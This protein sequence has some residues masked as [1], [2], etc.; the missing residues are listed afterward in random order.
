MVLHDSSSRSHV[1]GMLRSRRLLALVCLF[2]FAILTT[3]LSRGER[4][5]TE[6]PPPVSQPPQASEEH[7]PSL[8]V[9]SLTHPVHQLVEDGE[10]DFQA[11]R[12]RQ[13]RSLKDAV[14]EYRRRYKLPPPPHFD[15]WYHFAKKK[16]VELIDEFDGIYHMLLPF[17]ALEPAVI[18]E[19]TREVIG[20]DNALIVARIRDGEVVKMDGGGEMYEWHR[21]ATPIMLK[22]FVRWLPD[23]DLAFNIHDEPRVVLQHDDLARHVTI[24]KEDN[25]PRANNADKLTNSF[26]ARPA[27]MG[28]GTRIKE[29]KTTRFNRF[30][31][32][33]T[34]SSSRIS[35]P[36]DSAVRACLTDNCTD[37]TAA[38]SN[39]PLGFISNTSAFSDICNSPS[40]ERSFGM[41]DRPNAFDVTHDLIPIF[42]QSKVSSF[43]DILYPSP[44]YYMHRVTYD[45]E[46]DMPWEE[47]AANMYWRGSTTGGFSRDGGWRR[48]HRQKFLTKIQPHGQ[49]KV[50]LYD[51]TTEPAEWKEEQVSMQSMA[52][53]F[54]VKFTF[55]GQCDPGDCD[56]QR[57]F[58]G[59]VEP[60]NM[61]DAFAS[62]YL[63]DIDGNAFSGR[64]YAW[65]LSQSLVY[66]LAVFREWHDEWL[67]PWVHFVP[68]G[69]QGDEYVESVRYFDQEP[70]GQREAKHMAEAS[71]EWAQKVL[72]NEDMEVWYFRLLL[73]YGRLIDDNRPFRASFRRQLLRTA[74][75]HH[76]ASSLNSPTPSPSPEPSPEPANYERIEEETF[77]YYSPDYYYPVR[78]GEILNSRY[79]VISKLGKRETH[80]VVV[81]VGTRNSSQAD[82][83]VEV[84]EYLASLRSKHAG[85]AL[86]R[87]LIDHFDMPGRSSGGRHP[88][89]VFPVL[90]TPVDILRDKLPHRS[91]GEP[92][93]KAVVAQTLEALDFLHSEAGIVYT[94][95]KADNLILSIGD[96]SHLAEYV[97]A[98]LK[99]STPDKVDGD[100]FI[101]RT[102]DLI[103]VRRLG[104]PVLCDF[105]QARLESHPHS[106]LIM[107]Y[108]YRAPEVL[109]GA[110]WDNKVDIWSIAMLTWHLIED[111]PMFIPLDEQ[112]DPSTLVHLTQMVRV[113]GPPPLELLHRG[114]NSSEYFDRDGRLLV[115]IDVSAPPSLDDS[116]QTLEEPNRRLYHD[117]IRRIVRWLPEERPSAR[118]LLDDP[119]D[120]TATTHTAMDL[121][122]GV[123]PFTS[124]TASGPVDLGAAIPTANLR[125]RTVLITGGASG[126]GAA[127]AQRLASHGAYII[128]GDLASQTTRATELVAQLRRDSGHENHHFVAADVLS[129]PSQVALFAAAASLSP[130]GGIDCVVANAGIA[131]APEAVKFARPPPPADL[132]AGAAAAAIPPPA[133]KTVEVDLIGVL[134]TT[135]LALSYLPANPASSPCSPSGTSSNSNSHTPRDRH[136][137]LV[138]SMAGLMGLATHPL[139]TAAKHGVVG[140]F[141]ALRMTAAQ[142]D[143]IRVNMLCPYFVETPIMGPVGPLLCAGGELG[144]IDDVAEAAARLV[145]DDRIVGR[146][147]AIGGGQ[148]IWDV[149]A[150]DFEQSDLFTRRVIAV[151]N[152][153]ATARGWTGFVFDI[154]ARLTSP[155]R[156][157]VGG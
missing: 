39:L 73:E 10:R 105:G 104:P 109:L 86:V 149:Y 36:L 27:D 58:F 131:D 76:A 154:A 136:L 110:A 34:W 5:T 69:L 3:F 103:A 51:K 79:K 47:K 146:G 48:Q 11:L 134:Y 90:G 14:A 80:H 118:E 133:L 82:R 139:Y 2:G 153:V 112:Q 15:K 50:L 66:K 87:R 100:R 144:H 63:L 128:I 22:S 81:K 93:V 44:W 52:H 74:H 57:E 29:Y 94:D 70:S 32:Q 53:Y 40:F 140:L 92:L 143:G 127:M 113:L 108:Q 75:A 95:L 37:N 18:R 125:S 68:L 101:Y 138:A 43:Q 123:V 151:T 99:H 26:S 42:S 119:T 35:C 67:R 7:A 54:D 8:P 1:I 126:L 130:H 60:V 28:D 141:R 98:A 25:I 45:E 17:W 49:A 124:I 91:L 120:Q 77:D 55:I 62:R 16:G 85:A 142:T 6:S 19:R 152:I 84:L 9:S 96:L 20:F 41:F 157:L 97:D 23:M 4:P 132:A 107:P 121:S 24:A 147:L 155:L 64:Y 13:S 111:S 117:F 56:A 12:A 88:C 46:R 72:R 89:L 148:A 83:E 31:H 156:R 33:S 78:F 65:L 59:T 61:F 21:D 71:R 30:A 145:A 122:T 102:R 135:Y 116:G 106:G 129:W 38:Y 137:V 115:D 114:D 150:H